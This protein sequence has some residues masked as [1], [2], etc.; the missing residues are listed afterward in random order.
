MERAAI[1]HEI[2]RMQHGFQGIWNDDFGER[3][4]EA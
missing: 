1:F 2:R 4:K 3:R